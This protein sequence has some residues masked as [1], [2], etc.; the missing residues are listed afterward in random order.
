[1]TRSKAL[2]ILLSAWAI[3][4]INTSLDDPDPIFGHADN[5]EAVL[6]WFGTNCPTPEQKELFFMK[7]FDWVD[8]AS[9]RMKDIIRG[10]L[11]FKDAIFEQ[12]VEEV[13]L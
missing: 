13:W 1:M 10:E 6:I 4:W 7:F 2:L 9:N 3:R 12:I 11:T 5:S 8:H